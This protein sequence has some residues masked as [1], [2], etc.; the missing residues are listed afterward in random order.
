MATF[1]H[2]R[3]YLARGGAVMIHGGDSFAVIVN[4]LPREEEPRYIWQRIMSG[5]T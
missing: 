3:D 1:F 2:F 4:Y 5:C